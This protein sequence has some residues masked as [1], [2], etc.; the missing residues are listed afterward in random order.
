MKSPSILKA[1]LYS[2]IIGGL[3]TEA[4]L[5]VRARHHKRDDYYEYLTEEEWKIV[6]Q[7]KSTPDSNE[8]K[9]DF[10]VV[11][12]LKKLD[13]EDEVNVRTEYL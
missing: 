7:R 4:M 2:L 12:V 11:K 3:A 10:K 9:M 1:G 8:N 13:A 6:K 5:N